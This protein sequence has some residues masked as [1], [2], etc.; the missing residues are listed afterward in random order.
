MKT[1]DKSNLKELLGKLAGEYKVF[2]PSKVNE[3]TQYAPYN[4]ESELVL[5]ENVLMPPKDIF[6]P[7][8]EKM[9]TFKA[10]DKHVEIN[11]IP[12]ETDKQVI[13]GVRSCDMKS[14]DCLDQVF[15][16]RNFVDEFYKDKRDRSVFVALACNK[17]KPTCFCESMGLDP[18]K[19]VLADIQAYDLGNKYG[20]EAVTD[21]GT[22]LLSKVSGI[23]KE[24]KADVPKFEG[25]TLK[26]DVEGVPEK[27][28]GMFDD[29]MWA[30]ISRK[31]LN[32]NTCAYICPTCHCFDISEEVR[33]EDGAKIR[34]W[35]CC[36]SGEYTQMAAHQ[37]R[38][39]KKE[40]VRNRFMH[41]LNYFVERYNM[42][43]CVGCGR[44]V[45]KCPVNMDITAIIKKIKEAV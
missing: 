39:G 33:G 17:A 40:R 8:T 42:L 3:L 30:D 18:Q 14:I 35:D 24:E 41:K 37:P 6:F 44:C 7:Q 15:L 28:K 4:N 20:F 23:L 45:E 32:C 11:E 25:C 16:T 5:D 1:I 43:L 27:L 26:A 10:I 38:P 36:M 2:V 12:K 19:A 22:E 29:P 9:Y 21:K 34:C 13:F 31:C